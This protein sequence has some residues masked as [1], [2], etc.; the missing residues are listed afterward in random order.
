MNNEL[1]IIW[2]K[3]PEDYDYLR[4]G[5]ILCCHR[6]RFALKSHDPAKTTDGGPLAH[7]VAY[8]V[9]K[10]DACSSPKYCFERRYWWV[11]SYDRWKGC[12]PN[13]PHYRNPI[14][15]PAEAVMVSS[16][17]AGKTSKGFSQ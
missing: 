6:K 2:L 14:S 8:A 15:S 3:N 1:E 17:V 16:I 13:T 12:T 11:K 10:P 4:E 7:I 5:T 9:L